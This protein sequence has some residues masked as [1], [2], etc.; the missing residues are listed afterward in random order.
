MRAS[1][2]SLLLALPL[3]LWGCNAQNQ[4][5][6]KTEEVAA[7]TP[8]EIR[9]LVM[10]EIHAVNDTIAL[11]NPKTGENVSLVYS[12]VHQGVMMTPGGR[13]MVC[14]DF[15]ASDSTMFDVDYYLSKRDAQWFVTDVVVH[16]VGDEDFLTEVDRTRLGDVQ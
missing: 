4:A 9:S 10:E 5:E 16:K 15:A 6:T 13:Q 14:V 1:R 3:L 2:L 8:E 7:V 11:P 12:G